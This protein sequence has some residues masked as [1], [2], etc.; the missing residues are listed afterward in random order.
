MVY[1]PETT[2]RAGN[3][4]AMST[5][6]NSRHS[7]HTPSLQWPKEKLLK[8]KNDFDGG[9]VLQNYWIFPHVICSSKMKFGKLKWND[10]KQNWLKLRRTLIIYIRFY[11]T[12]IDWISMKPPQDTHIHS[13]RNLCSKIT[14]QKTKSIVLFYIYV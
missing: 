3:F 13:G 10:S 6:L 11:I 2:V 9:F 8:R 12:R 1:C 14:N 7:L 4:R 5:Y